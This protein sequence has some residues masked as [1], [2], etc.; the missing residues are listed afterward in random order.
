M[1]VS[2]T[3]KK[4]SNFGQIDIV[5]DIDKTIA[6]PFEDRDLPNK[7]VLNWFKENN[8]YIHAVTA[9][10]LYPGTLEFIRYLFSIPNANVHFYS[11]GAQLRNCLFVKKLLKRALGQAE[12]EKIEEKT[13]IFSTRCDEN[14]PYARNTYAAKYLLECF[15]LTVDASD[16]PTKVK[17][18]YR[19][20]G[21]FSPDASLANVILIDDNPRYL[22]SCAQASNLL[23]VP[24]LEELFYSAPADKTQNGLDHIYYLTGLLEHTIQLGGESL[25]GNLFRI[26]FVSNGPIKYHPIAD[27]LALKADYYCRGLVRLRQINPYLDFSH[28]LLRSAHDSMLMEDISHQ[29]KV[30]E[31]FALDYSAHEELEEDDNI[32]DVTTLNFKH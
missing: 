5:L 22:A 11:A 19:L 21:G 8:L 1:A 4:A 25:A 30:R 29:S 6:I 26:Q 14:I 18:L 16:D 23:M 20:K 9:H 15:G 10:L 3:E 7:H 28:I 31:A 24:R 13:L 2:R 32:F 27:Q 12:Y 17:D